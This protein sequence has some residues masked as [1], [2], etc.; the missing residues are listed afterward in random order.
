MV[1][2]LFGSAHAVEL[3]F[4]GR[5]DVWALAQKVVHNVLA[6]PSER[7]SRKH[8]QNRA[9]KGVQA[10]SIFLPSFSSH[11]VASIDNLLVFFTF[12]REYGK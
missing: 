3:A 8:T 2:H 10:V 6:V 5:F 4:L 7:E 11:L 9:I 12:Q 1:S